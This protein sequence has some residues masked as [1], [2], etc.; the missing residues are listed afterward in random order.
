M[1]GEGLPTPLLWPENSMNCIVH[2]VAKSPMQLSGFHFG[3]LGGVHQE[4]EQIYGQ[5][6]HSILVLWRLSVSSWI[7]SYEGQEKHYSE[8]T[9]LMSSAKQ[10]HKKG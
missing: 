10:S 7:F 6:I 4:Q 3:C 9:D 1:P 8:V 5:T 2:G